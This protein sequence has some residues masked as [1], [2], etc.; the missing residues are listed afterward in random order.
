[1]PIPFS[2]TPA[3][4]GRAFLPTTSTCASLLANCPPAVRTCFACVHGK[5]EVPEDL[6]PPFIAPNLCLIGGEDKY[7]SPLELELIGQL[8]TVTMYY[9]QNFPCVTLILYTCLTSFPSWSHFPG[10]S[11]YK[12]FLLNHCHT[13]SCLR[14][15]FWETQPK[16]VTFIASPLVYYCL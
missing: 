1:M 9:F 16:T 11:S 6:C 5:P 12:Q 13:N 10:G 2:C 7:S 8:W 3:P 14:L 4:G 15:C